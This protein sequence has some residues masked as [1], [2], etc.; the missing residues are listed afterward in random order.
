MKKISILIVSITL[1]LGL[2]LTS[3]TLVKAKTDSYIDTKVEANI[4]DSANGNGCF[5]SFYEWF[6]S[7]DDYIEFLKLAFKID[8]N[9]FIQILLE[10]GK[11]AQ[12]VGYIDENASPCI[13]YISS[14][15]LLN[16]WLR[17]NAY[18]EYGAT[19]K[20]GITGVN[21]SNGLHYV[22]NGYDALYELLQ[23]KGELQ[24]Y[25]LD[26]EDVPDVFYKKNSEAS[27]YSDTWYIFSDLKKPYVINNTWH[28]KALE[29]EGLVEECTVLDLPNSVG[30]V[31]QVSLNTYE[32]IY[33]EVYYNDEFGYYALSQNDTKIIQLS[34]SQLPT[35]I[36]DSNGEVKDIFISKQ[37]SLWAMP[38]VKDVNEKIIVEYVLREYYYYE[39]SIAGAKVKYNL[40][41]AYLSFQDKNGNFIPTD[42]I[43]EIELNF[44]MQEE[45]TF[46]TQI[47]HIFGYKYKTFQCECLLKRGDVVDAPVFPEGP[48]ISHTTSYKDKDLTVIQ[49]GEYDII[50][51]TGEKRS[52]SYSLYIADEK[53]QV[54]NVNNPFAFRTDY[55]PTN[56][57]NICN[58]KI[59]Y[60]QIIYDLKNIDSI[61]S[62]PI[63]DHN[64]DP[65]LLD[66]I[67]EFIL[68][69]W[70]SGLFGKILVIL[71]GLLILFPIIYIV[72]QLLKLVR[73][74]FFY[75]KNKKSTS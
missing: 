47:G 5:I 4:P 64:E 14:E 44:I 61:G 33:S 2:A 70:N 36:F 29:Y 72:I 53:K 3:K 11:K 57:L 37:E 32:Y 24:A 45:P 68:M 58:L 38:E 74:F 28:Y 13:L 41:C 66:K 65:T 6:E 16:K 7:N 39:L 67:I 49:K 21:L 42:T 22:K 15:E 27:T 71:V 18:I 69:I 9:N 50:L 8:S 52:Y 31:K 40:L 19:Y 12:N 30:K 17:D 35:F 54:T 60:R 73:R 1:V 43:E 51:N 55:H 59:S 20:D 26:P 34:K 48:L 75:I 25:V 10:G 46:F 23:L 62:E 63:I 56:E